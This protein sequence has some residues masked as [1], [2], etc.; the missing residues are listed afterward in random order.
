MELSYLGMI[1]CAA[2]AAIS[3]SAMA[4]SGVHMPSEFEG[5]GTELGR[6]F[7]YFGGVNGYTT[8]VSPAL[9]FSGSSCE[10]G[11][12]FQHDTFFRVAGVGVGT[13]GINR[14][15]LAI[16]AGAD[17]FS[18]TINWPYARSLSCKVT[19]REDDNNDGMIDAAGDDDQ[20]ESG[21][22]MLQQGA[23]VYN[24]ALSALSDVNSGN[25]NDVQNFGATNRMAFFLTFE[26]RT[27]Y[28]GG[29]IETPVTFWVDHVGFYVGAQVFP[30]PPLCAA[31]WNRS[32]ALDS[33]D[34]FDYLGSF[35]AGDGDFNESGMTD[36]QDFF[37]FLGA[38]FI[39]C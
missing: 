13:L 12:N 29:I 33:Q 36:S 25:G 1:G 21:I 4:Q 17:T 7:S 2:L 16:P 22:F 3:G 31:D 19:V 37:E 23:H 26:S 9:V 11:I 39:G 15:N 18:M 10:I 34:F 20:W 35:F 38:F 14:P 32:G 30:P 8:S 28:A 27:T 6:L 5:A 24:M